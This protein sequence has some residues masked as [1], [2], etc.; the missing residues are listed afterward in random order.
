MTHLQTLRSASPS[1]RVAHPPA[2]PWTLCIWF[3]AD[4]TLA[5]IYL[6]KWICVHL[7]LFYCRELS[8]LSDRC[9]LFCKTCPSQTLMDWVQNLI[10]LWEILAFKF[11]STYHFSIIEGWKIVPH[12]WQLWASQG[13]NFRYYVNLSEVLYLVWMLR[14]SSKISDSHTNDIIPVKWFVCAKNNCVHGAECRFHGLLFYREDF[15]NVLS[16]RR[17]T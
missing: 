6:F 8:H 1:Y 14:T 15:G 17:R 7:L 12:F 9:V 10:M 3:R 11:I 4:V 5:F 2:F 16:K 13:T